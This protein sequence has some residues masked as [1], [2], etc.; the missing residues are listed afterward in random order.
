[1]LHHIWKVTPVHCLLRITHLLT[2]YLTKAKHMPHEQILP[3]SGLLVA[4]RLRW[5]LYQKERLVQRLHEELY[6][7]GQIQRE[8]NENSLQHYKSLCNKALVVTQQ[9][10]DKQNSDIQGLLKAWET[11]VHA[12]Q[13]AI[14]HQNQ[15]H[16]TLHVQMSR[17]H[18]LVEQRHVVEMENLRNQFQCNMQAQRDE[19][20]QLANANLASALQQHDNEVG[21][22]TAD[23]EQ[24][25]RQELDRTSKA[26]MV[27]KEREL[28]NIAQHYSHREQDEEHQSHPSAA[29]PNCSRSV[30]QEVVSSEDEGE[31]ADGA[32]PHIPLMTK[33]IAKAFE[34]TKKIKDREVTLEKATEPNHHRDFILGEAQCLL[35]DEF[36][37]TQDI[38]FVA[39]QLASVDDVQAYEGDDGPGP[40]LDDLMFD[41]GQNYASPWNSC[42]LDILLC[43]FQEH[44]DK[45][46]WPVK[47]SNNYIWE[48][49][50]NRYKRLRSV[51]LNGQPKLI[52]NGV[53]ETPVEKYQRQ[54]AV[55]DHIVKLRAKNG[56]DDLATW[57]WLQ[58]LVKLLGEQGMSSEESAIENN[59]DIVDVERIIDSDI[60]SHRGAKP[61]KGLPV[62]LYDR[63]WL[64]GLAQQEVDF[65]EMSLNRFIWMKV[66]TV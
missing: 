13:R 43:K 44:C 23:M 2:S 36:G 65:L 46:N 49:I 54:V 14:D 22:K 19:L 28:A 9:K 45:E 7:Q 59:L 32:A 52:Q 27:E 20:L 33:A 62:D 40:D 39:H 25:M 57:E 35:K 15:E 63:A 42:V 58:R 64:T 1:M 3:T 61:V 18:E 10:F 21:I 24:R 60:F 37:I 50:K 17:D 6:E 53:L 16:T 5:E 66:A 34:I 56:D 11:E 48:V 51:W 29:S 38:D 31:E 30:P 41:L 4:K 8:E 26:M 47:K 55:L 12:L